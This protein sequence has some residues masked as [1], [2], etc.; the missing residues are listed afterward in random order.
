[1]RRC[2]RANCA[3]SV[4]RRSHLMS[5]WRRATPEA[6][7]GTSSRMRSYGVAVPPRR[8]LGR[9]AAHDARREPEP[10]QIGAHPLEPRRV[11]VERGQLDVGELQQ[12]RGLAAGRRAGIE[13]AH[14][15]GEIEQRRRE[16][17]R[18][19]PAPT[20]A[21]RRSPGMRSTGS[22]VSSI[23]AAAPYASPRMPCAREQR[24]VTARRRCGGGSRAA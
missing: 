24:Q 2:V 8:R 9:V 18:R 4:A 21:P 15:V 6:L 14:A 17:R 11:A 13:H 16:L 12:V 23:T 5:G 22:G 7:H 19:R 20:P 1:M 3:M 10:R